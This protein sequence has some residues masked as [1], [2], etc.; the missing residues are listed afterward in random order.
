ML[1][2]ATTILVLL[3][4]GWF[5]LAFRLHQRLQ[6]IDPGLS[7]LIGKPSLFWTAWHG[8][9]VLI[10]MIRSPDLAGGRFAPLAPLASLLRAW[11]VAMILAMGW[12][13][14]SMLAG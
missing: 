14:V 12:V 6:A 1:E 2:V 5:Y 13:F 7:A 10:D 4:A 8:H 9:R 11:A 3:Y